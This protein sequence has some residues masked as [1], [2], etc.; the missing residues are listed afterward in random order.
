MR[1]STHSANLSSNAK[2]PGKK[3]SLELISNLDSDRSAWLTDVVLKSSLL[4]THD[5][6]RTQGNPK[7]HD[8][9]VKILGSTSHLIKQDKESGA[10]A[11]GSKV[12][13]E[14]Q[15]DIKDPSK[16]SGAQVSTSSGQKTGKHSLASPV[17]SQAKLEGGEQGS[18]DELTRLREQIVCLRIES[19]ARDV[20]HT[21]N[22]RRK[23]NELLDAQLAAVNA[24]PSE[25]NHQGFFG[26]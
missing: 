23:Q 12:P 11:A 2:A 17:K 21:H 25:R 1:L 13:S 3:L 19:R 7:D 26:L 6:I 16:E 4:G 8:H 15:E 22:L 24:G 10:E 20:E 5:T 9:D 14:K 18:D